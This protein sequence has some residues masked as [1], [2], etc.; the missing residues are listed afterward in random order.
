[1]FDIVDLATL[2]WSYCSGSHGERMISRNREFVYIGQR[3]A[4]LY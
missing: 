4:P 3:Q 2:L 1:M